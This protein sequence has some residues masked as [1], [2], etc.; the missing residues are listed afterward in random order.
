VYR[1]PPACR[2]RC[3]RLRSG[4]STQSAIPGLWQMSACPLP[5]GDDRIGEIAT[6]PTG[7]F[8]LRWP[9][10]DGVGDLKQWMLLPVTVFSEPP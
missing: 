10:G 2:S 4:T 9:T 1:L 5:E 6:C 7:W 3:R 8:Q